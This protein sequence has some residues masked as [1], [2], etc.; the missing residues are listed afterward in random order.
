MFYCLGPGWALA[1]R[2]ERR[3]FLTAEINYSSRA[4]ILRPGARQKGIVPDGKQVF[5]D[6][7]ATDGMRSDLAE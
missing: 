4:A 6:T 7:Y 1:K 3:P 5:L 2:W